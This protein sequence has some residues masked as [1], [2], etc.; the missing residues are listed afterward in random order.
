[1]FAVGG[2]P[3]NFSMFSSISVLQPLDVSSTPAVHSGY[4]MS[5]WGKVYSCW[6]S[7]GIEHW[8]REKMISFSS[9]LTMTCRPNVRTI[10][11]W[12][13]CSG[14]FFS[15]HFLMLVYYCPV[16][17][18]N[19]CSFE[20]QVPEWVIAPWWDTTN[21]DLVCQELSRLL[22]TRRLWAGYSSNTEPWAGQ[23]AQV[24]WWFVGFVGLGDMISFA[25]YWVSSKGSLTS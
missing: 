21:N 22:E 7:P 13:S 14:I 23:A 19:V 16:Q 1:M 6:R 25:L 9:A 10:P 4:Q 17:Y 20:K 8:P 12:S 2:L 5:L 15:L 3:L 18:L 24:H 11:V